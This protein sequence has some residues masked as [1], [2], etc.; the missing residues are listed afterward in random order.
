[1]KT[2]CS[3]QLVEA[4]IKSG[5]IAILPILNRIAPQAAY[6]DL[7]TRDVPTVVEM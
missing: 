4:S 7:V 6:P 2:T 5:A 3:P 1:V